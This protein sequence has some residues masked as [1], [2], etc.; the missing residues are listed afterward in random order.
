[1]RR[2]KSGGFQGSV[3]GPCA[4]GPSASRCRRRK[5]PRTTAL[6]RGTPDPHPARRWAGLADAR[7]GMRLSSAAGTRGLR[8]PLGDS[9]EVLDAS[10]RVQDAVRSNG[11]APRART[12]PRRERYHRRRGAD[13]EDEPTGC[14][15]VRRVRGVGARRPTARRWLRRRSRRGRGADDR[16][17]RISP[18]AA[19]SRRR[20]APRRAQRRRTTLTTTPRTS[21]RSTRTGFIRAFAGSRR[22][23]PSGIR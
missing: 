11:A 10:P 6:P 2:Q 22:M 17:A 19:S 8:V 1:M 18:R 9:R 14:D 15:P 5:D 12:G 20:A 7:L 13:E 21:A 4:R 3:L 23:R 16:P